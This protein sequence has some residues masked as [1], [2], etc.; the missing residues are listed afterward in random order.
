MVPMIYSYKNQYFLCS[1]LLLFFAENKN[2]NKKDGEKKIKSNVTKQKSTGIDGVYPALVF[3]PRYSLAL[4]AF[5]C[6]ISSIEV[7]N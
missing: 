3:P 4:N 2:K 7:N 6:G 5:L 1:S